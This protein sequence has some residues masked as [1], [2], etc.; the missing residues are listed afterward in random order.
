MTWFSGNCK[1]QCMRAEIDCSKC[2]SPLRGSCH[3]SPQSQRACI[4]F[5]NFTR[6]KSYAVINLI[7][8]IVFET[9]DHKTNE[10]HTYVLRQPY[11]SMCCA[12]TR[13]MYICVVTS[14]LASKQTQ[15]I[16]YAST[17]QA[18]MHARGES[19]IQQV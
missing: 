3:Y 7:T 13:G 1:N 10:R 18:C 4:D 11:H 2:H 14:S 19:C 15:Q 6:T 17:I 8:L 12:C 5:Y 16:K 9:Y